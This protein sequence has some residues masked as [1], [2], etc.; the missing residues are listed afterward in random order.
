M[1]R[2]G[3]FVVCVGVMRWWDWY[4]LITSCMLWYVDKGD[5]VRMCGYLSDSELEANLRLSNVF[6]LV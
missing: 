4:A 6:G 3:L 1:V 2:V 5:Q